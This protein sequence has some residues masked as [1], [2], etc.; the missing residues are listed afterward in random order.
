MTP[1]R[2][3]CI[4]A[5]GASLLALASDRGRADYPAR[6]VRIIVG[7]RRGGADIAARPPAMAVRPPRLQLLSIPPGAASNIGTEA[8]GISRRLYAL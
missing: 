3:F 6:P 8:E 4:R 7:F 1:V 5:V 2:N